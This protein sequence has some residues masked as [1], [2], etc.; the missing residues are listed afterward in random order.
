MSLLIKQLAALVPVK[1]KV[2]DKKSCRAF[3]VEVSK[4]IKFIL[5]NDALFDYVYRLISD[6]LQTEDILFES[7]NEETVIELCKCQNHPEGLRTGRTNGQDN[8]EV[9]NPVLII[10][11]ISQ[12][13]SVINAMKNK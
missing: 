12:I 5:N 11:L 9:I 3:L 8:P 1:H 7:V 10:S 2:T 4:H 6:Q 13:I